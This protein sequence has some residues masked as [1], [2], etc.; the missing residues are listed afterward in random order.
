M[1]LEN[2][3]VHEPQ[4]EKAFLEVL[5]YVEKGS[6]MIELGSYWGFYSLWFNKKIK[7]KNKGKKT[8]GNTRGKTTGKTRG[9]TRGKTGKTITS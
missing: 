8:R 5:N 1:L 3:G 7:G 2:K 9:N 4:E 6:T